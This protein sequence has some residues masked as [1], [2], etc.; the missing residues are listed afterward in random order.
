MNFDYLWHDNDFI[1]GDVRRIKT[2]KSYQM[3]HL[4]TM[5]YNS[6]DSSK[7]QIGVSQRKR[8]RHVLIIKKIKKK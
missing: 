7:N 6:S 1:N 4:V 8:V 5:T 2:K 3:C